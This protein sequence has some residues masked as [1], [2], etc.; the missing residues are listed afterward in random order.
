MSTS[1]I[2]NSR[3]SDSNELENPHHNIRG[4]MFFLACSA[5]LFAVMGVFVREVSAEVNNET[6]VFFR[7]LVAALIFIPLII[8]NKSGFL[9][10][11]RI[12]LHLFRTVSG[13]TAMYCFFYLIGTLKLTDAM[14]FNYSA[15]IYIPLIAWFWL[16]E[17]LSKKQYYSVI[18]GF[19]GVLMILKPTQGILNI[20]SL[21]GLAAGSLAACAFLSVQQLGKTESPLLTVFYFSFFSSLISAVPMLWAY[22]GV[23][24]WQLLQLI[25]IG[26]LATLSQFCLT[27]AYSLAPASQISPVQ[28]LSIVFAGIF[29]W[30]LWSE[31]PDIWSYGGA[32]C[33]VGAALLT[34][35]F[36]RKTNR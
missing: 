36:S 22:Q 2:S 9:R 17:P 28:Y 32:A 19:I 3:G 31:V 16:S 27:K 34:L 1:P 35:Q 15:P 6:V 20:N 8:K 30:L 21:A 25:T 23:T 11:D 29:G 33:I 5:F 12:G 14:L 10:T 13:L 18:I 4:G 26:V 24:Q 7:N